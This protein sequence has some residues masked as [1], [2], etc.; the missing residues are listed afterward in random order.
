M[1]KISPD[2]VLIV[3]VLAF[4]AAYLWA[5]SLLPASSLGDP[6]GPRVFP[7]LVGGGLLLSAVLMVVEMVAKSRAVAPAEPAPATD[8]AHDAHDG[9]TSRHSAL[10]LLGTAAWTAAY[11]VTLERAGYLIGTVVFLGGLL[12]Y[13][14]R[15]RYWTNAIVAVAF[16]LIVDALFTHVLGTPMPEGWLAI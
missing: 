12:S 14:N 8:D 13:F 10:A 4:A 11:Y 6:L 7:A 2:A 16:T 1:K 5:D 15:G 3:C 9:P